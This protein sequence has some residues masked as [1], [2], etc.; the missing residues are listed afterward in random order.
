MSTG[1]GSLSWTR[2]NNLPIN[3]RL[4][5]QLSYEGLQVQTLHD[6][7]RLANPVPGDGEHAARLTHGL[8]L[9]AARASSSAG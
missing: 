5:C 6:L 4:L 8:I 1:G 3:S 9:G 2:T 7:T